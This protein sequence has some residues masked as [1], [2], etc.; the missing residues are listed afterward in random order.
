M[1]IPHLTICD[2]P[3][4][5][6]KGTENT[7]DWA[8]CHMPTLPVFRSLKQEDCKYKASLGYKYELFSKQKKNQV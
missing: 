2:S 7:V 5:K 1:E 6:L 3:Q 8:W 4:Q